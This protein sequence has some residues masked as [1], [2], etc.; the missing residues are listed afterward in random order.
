MVD[1]AYDWS[2]M[3]WGMR[4]VV[5]VLA[6]ALI[7]VVLSP[8][9]S[10]LKPIA[11]GLGLTTTKTVY[12]PINHTVYVNRTVYVPP[13]W[14]SSLESVASGHGYCSG[15]L[16]VLP[17]NTAWFVWFWLVPSQYAEQLGF[18]MPYYLDHYN[19]TTHSAQFYR[20][21]AYEFVSQGMDYMGSGLCF[22]DNVTVNGY[23]AAV[24]GDTVGLGPMNT[25]EYPISAIIPPENATYSGVILLSLSEHGGYDMNTYHVNTVIA[26]NVTV[27]YVSNA[28]AALWLPVTT[29]QTIYDY[30]N[31]AQDLTFGHPPGYYSPYG[32]TMGFYVW[33]YPS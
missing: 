29:N 12:V 3:S 27:T 6:V 16:V 4:A 25:I 18:F 17:N 22:F 7:L 30:W 5:I 24:C 20:W 9:V 1:L 10:F 23:Y 13:Q 31:Y 26:C 19:A 33:R 21:I 2:L 11:E 28:T 32:N 14:L 8:H 15:R